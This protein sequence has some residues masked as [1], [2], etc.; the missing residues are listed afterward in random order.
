MYKVEII[1]S[2]NKVSVLKLQVFDRSNDQIA[3]W[4][5][6]QHFAS[7]SLPLRISR[8]W[9]SQCPLVMMEASIERGLMEIK[10]LSLPGVKLIK[11][12][13]FKDARGFFRETFRK[14]FYAEA[15]IDCDF[16]QDNHSYSVQNTL[17]GMHFQRSPGQAKLVSVMK[18]KIY[19]VFVDIRPDS[20]TFRK[21]DGVYLDAEN[22]E[23]LFIPVGYAHGFC[24]LSEDAHLCYKVSN[25]YDPDEE[26]SFRYDDPTI[27]IAWPI[28]TPFLSE[29]DLACPFLQE[30]IR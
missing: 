16:V 13:V 4:W 28:E 15:G 11:L 5:K 27:G 18:G 22:G 8:V 30:A 26:R 14:P 9:T 20:P 29:R 25:I 21:W 19:D 6:A 2:K 17:R 3:V 10:E 24:V 7:K 1:L 23:Q 12:R